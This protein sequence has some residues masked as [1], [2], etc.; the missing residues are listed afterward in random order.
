MKAERFRE[1]KAKL[2]KRLGSRQFWIRNLAAMAAFTVLTALALRIHMDQ[3]EER[4]AQ[5][6][7]SGS[8]IRFHV[9]A[10][11]DREK[12]QELK[13]A[14][15]DALLA[16][17]EVLLEGA[18]SLEEARQCLAGNLDVLKQE[19]EQTVQEAGSGERVSLALTREE[20]P[21]RVY[22]DYRFPAGEYETLQVKLG[23]GKGRNWWCLLFPSLCFRDSLHP[24]LAGKEERKLKYILS[25]ETYDRIL[26]KDK[27]SIGFLW[28]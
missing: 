15:R 14:V 25:D 28:F 17:M 9:L 24:V 8:V 2:G 13:L 1:W 27:V 10:D 7:L 21:V 22:G 11:S 23:S 16:C 19:A 12:D 4:A 5:E 3:M 26:Q 20:F 18:G 6:E